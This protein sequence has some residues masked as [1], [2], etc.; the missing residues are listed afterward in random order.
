MTLIEVLI[1]AAIIV[2]ICIAS[3][4]L[5]RTHYFALERVSAYTSDLFALQGKLEELRATPFD[6]LSSLGEIDI[7]QGKITITKVRDDLLKIDAVLYRGRGEPLRL[8]TMRSR[9]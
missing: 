4:E 5:I 7:A 1:S 6:V 3:A 9:Y 8:T 2:L